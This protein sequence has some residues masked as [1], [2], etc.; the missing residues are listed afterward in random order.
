MIRRANDLLAAADAH[1]KA[2]KS[3]RSA[4]ASA[5]LFKLV[6]QQDAFRIRVE[7]AARTAK[8]QA[9]SRAPHTELEAGRGIVEALGRIEIQ[10]TSLVDIMRWSVSSS[11]F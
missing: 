7:R 5:S 10:L 4:A 11:R 1:V 3:S 2:H 8:H 6:A 9:Q